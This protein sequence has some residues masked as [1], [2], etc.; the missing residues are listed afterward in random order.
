LI[1]AVTSFGKYDPNGGRFIDSYIRHWEPTIRLIVAW[2]TAQPDYV[3]GFDLLETEPAKSFYARHADNKVIRGLEEGHSKWGP[4]AKRHQY[5]F[6]H[7]AWKFSHKVF[8]VCAAA[9]YIEKGKLFWVDA[10]VVTHQRPP[11]DLFNTLLPDDVN[12][13]YLARPGYHSEL[14]FVGYNLRKKKTRNFLVEYEKQ[15]SEDLFLQDQ[16]WDD[17][18]QF[19]YLVAKRGPIVNHIRH[20]S[21]AHPFDDSILR[22]YM[23]HLKG[24]RKSCRP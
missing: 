7:D 19:D 4:K 5:S 15:Y 21:N 1:T 10:D 22:H 6:R 18:N 8:A 3:Q 23:T 11:L 17:C 16:F 13:C 24:A 9:R 14:G 20:K 12:M 2:E